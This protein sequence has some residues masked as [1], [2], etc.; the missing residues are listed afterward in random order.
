MTH[1]RGDGGE[2]DAAKTRDPVLRFAIVLVAALLESLYL[3]LRWAVVACPRWGGRD[4]PKMF[5]F[6][7]FCD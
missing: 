7:T 6:K 4:L 1:V 5:T 2:A 3:V